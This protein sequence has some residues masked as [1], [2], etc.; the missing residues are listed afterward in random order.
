MNLNPLGPENGEKNDARG[1]ERHDAR[2]RSAD[3]LPRRGDPSSVPGR[4]P[5][6]ARALGQAQDHAR[7]ASQPRAG[8][9][10]PSCRRRTAVAGCRQSPCRD[11]RLPGDFTQVSRLGHPLVNE[12][13]IGLKDKD[14]FN[15]SEPKNDGQFA[16]YVTHPTLPVLIQALFGVT[17]PPIPR[18]DLVQV[19]LTGVPGLNQ[20]TNVRPSEMLRLNT[21][22][23]PVA[24]ASQNSL[25]VHW[26]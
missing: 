18:D 3:Q 23:A 4:P 5:A 25:G 10:H 22:I 7:P 12:L 11:G 2:P 17:P 21:N 24:P 9:R 16:S 14:T 6:Q 26:R 8:R 15:A 1:Q 19:F 20:P 13:V